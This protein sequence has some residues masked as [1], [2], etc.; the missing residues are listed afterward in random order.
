[1][2]ILTD[3]EEVRQLLH[4]D[5]IWAAYALGDLGADMWPKTTWH[6]AGDELA[7]VLRAYH[8]PILWASGTLEGL[9]DEFSDAP[10]YSV[11]IRPSALPA[12]S[13][14]YRTGGLKK[15]WRMRLKAFRLAPVEGALR[16]TAAD[17]PDLERLYADGEADGQAPEFFFGDMVT[18]GVFYGCREGGQ[19]IAVAGTHL[20]VPEERV[21]TLGNVYTRRDCRG[22]G[23]SSRV[24]SAVVTELQRLE[25]DVIALNVYQSNATARGVYERL[26]F[27]QYCDF[28]EGIIEKR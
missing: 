17:L 7:L 16:L 1:M 24:T 22:R 27:R 12:L 11:Q 19:L 20:V 28:V 9:V 8:V 14:S 6:R 13:R 23:L 21:A 26:G 25:I 2:P 15:M 18:H 3:R 4:R 10:H 5:A